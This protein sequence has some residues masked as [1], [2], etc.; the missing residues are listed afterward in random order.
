[1]SRTYIGPL[2]RQAQRA[3]VEAAHGLPLRRLRVYAADEAH[4][5]A[6]RALRL[7]CAPPDALAVQLRERVQQGRAQHQ[8]AHDGGQPDGNCPATPRCKHPARHAGA[9][10]DMQRAAPRLAAGSMQP[11]RARRRGA[12]GART[13]VGSDGDADV[14][15]GAA[16]LDHLG[17]LRALDEE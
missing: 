1:M 2:E 13:V 12:D 10:Q 14:A 5:L 3:R 16:P 8:D 15:P 7:R 9:S 4:G 17:G 6:L 11:R